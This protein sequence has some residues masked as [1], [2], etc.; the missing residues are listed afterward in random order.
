MPM[1]A[2]ASVTAN[3]I[4][5][6]PIIAPRASGCRAVPWMAVPDDT[7]GSGEFQWSHWDFFH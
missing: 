1:I 5:A 4:Q 2:S 7:E 6:V 3:P